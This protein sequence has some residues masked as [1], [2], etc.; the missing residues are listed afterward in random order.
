[1]IALC[2][3]ALSAA[4]LLVEL[5][6]T[7]SHAVRL[8]P[9]VLSTSTSRR[10]WRWVF[11]ISGVVSAILIQGWFRV[12]KVI[13]GGDLPPP[14]AT[15]VGRLF[16]P[17]LGGNL[18]GANNGAQNLPQTVIIS[19]VAHLTGSTSLAQRAF[20]TLLVT[21]AVLSALALLRMLGVSPIPAMA[22]A[23]L[24]IFNP[25]VL[26]GASTNPVF[27]AA[28]MLLPALPAIVLAAAQGRI[29]VG[30]AV[31]LIGAL[32]PL[33]GY[34]YDNPPLVGM[35]LVAIVV[36]P[37]T[38]VALDGRGAGRR[39][40]VTVLCA[41]TLLCVT[42]AFWIVP[43]V[44]QQ[45]EVASTQ[46]SS[47][48]SWTWTEQ[49]ATLG[50]AFW[51]N[52]SWSWA[53]PEYLPV[54]AQYETLPLAA[55]RFL[56]P[57]LAF[58]SLAL[59]R[60]RNERS[61]AR[62]AVLATV[63]ALSLIV[64]STG[65]NF[66]GAPI[67]NALYSLPLG[68]LLREPGRFLMVA[69]L[70]YAVLSALTIQLLIDRTSE[71][72]ARH[73]APGSHGPVSFVVSRLRRSLLRPWFRLAGASTIAAAAL[74]V[75]GV[76]SFPIV[77]GA[78]V[79]DNR[80]VLPPL[81]VSVPDYWPRMATA[82]DRNS[83]RGS[84]VVLPLDDFYQMP[85]TWGYYGADTFITD[86]ISRSV[87]DPV[88]EGYI[89]AGPQLRSA[90][91]LL[92]EAILAGNS[93]EAT[94][95]LAVMG[96]PLVLVRGD[97]DAR[98]PGRQLVSPTTLDSALARDTAFSL[99]QRAGP[100]ALY[101]ANQVGVADLETSTQVVTVRSGSPDLR[102]LQVLPPSAQLVTAPPRAGIDTA[103]ELN[104]ESWQQ[105]PGMLT[106]T[107][108]E[109]AGW[110]YN[111]AV[112]DGPNATVAD[113]SKLR[114]MFPGLTSQDGVD[115]NGVQ[116]L[117]LSLSVGANLL[118]GVGQMNGGWDAVGDCYDVLPISQTGIHSRQL[119]GAAPSGGT[120]LELSANLDIA[121]V[122][123]LL[124]PT[125][126]G[127]PLL[128]SLQARHVRGANPRVCLWQAGV[129]QCAPL[130]DI[131]ASEGWHHYST[132]V[133]PSAG[134]TSLS[135]FLYSDGGSQYGATINQYADASAVALPAPYDFVLLG[136][137]PSTGATPDLLTFFHHSDDPYW[138]GLP[139]D[140]GR[141]KVDGLLLGWLR[142]ANASI[143]GVEYGPTDLIAT[144]QRVSLVGGIGCGV[145]AVWR[146]GGIFGR[147]RLGRR[148]RR[149]RSHG[150]IGRGAGRVHRSLPQQPSATV[151]QGAAGGI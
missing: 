76:A 9:V 55:T 30:A 59:V 65:T 68:W 127:Q 16:L 132:I 50:N 17:W 54:A 41:G 111:L 63:L 15:G 144:G 110:R 77:S 31:A 83:A 148:R 105:R 75:A 94:R 49:R 48:A 4:L 81:H 7:R 122:S 114:A 85:Y 12:G 26:S 23:L 25:Y 149:R 27:L 33:V 115:T 5:G 74:V 147:R 95:L 22:G 101:R 108:S 151:G 138:K 11:L 64:L 45:H 146:Q 69:A 20:Y 60:S 135:L 78:V 133:R 139:D 91:R 1:M 140:A 38:A 137:A 57:I 102:V 10:Q 142:P 109:P 126:P 87:I 88:A 39:A 106:T 136:S 70:A 28:L 141:V 19:L 52:T 96:S 37:L 73:L 103:T 145:L 143:A 51:L 125:T 121:C 100:L 6:V 129:D 43:A 34:V 62:V 134:A 24:Y 113:P 42:C 67:F 35:L 47:L 18:G 2:M 82:I 8:E 104:L 79:P 53:F 29:R 13:A 86:L 131:P 36:T 112:L 93:V 84:V 32:A 150:R 44:V 14:I 119:P 3:L 97:V 89:P 40:V 123:Q 116:S 98:F 128:V 99:V 21:G 58:S 92:S 46:L 124:G 120:A 118:K 107:V 66:P 56:L 80:P 72:I 71:Q 61:V 117:R 130:P 90:V